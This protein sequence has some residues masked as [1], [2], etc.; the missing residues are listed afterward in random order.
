MDILLTELD[1]SVPKCVYIV[2]N[3]TYSNIITLLKLNEGTISIIPQKF[4][5]YIE[6]LI[7]LVKSQKNER[8]LKIKPLQP[9]F[10]RDGNIL[11]KGSGMSFLPDIPIDDIESLFG[12]FSFGEKRSS[13]FNK[14]VISYSA[15][16]AKKQLLD[17]RIN[18]RTYTQISG[19][20]YVII[21]NEDNF[22]NTSL[23]FCELPSATSISSFS[24]VNTKEILP[25]TEIKSEWQEFTDDDTGKIYYYN[26]STKVSVWKDSL[27]TNKKYYHKYLK[28]KQK[29]IKIHSRELEG[30]FIGDR[31][32]V[33]CPLDVRDVIKKIY[34]NNKEFTDKEFFLFLTG[35]R[36][37]Y[38]EGKSP[39]ISRT[40]YECVDNTFWV[41]GLGLEK[42]LIDSLHLEKAK[43][44]IEE[45]IRNESSIKLQE[46]HYDG[47]N[48]DV[49]VS[50]KNMHFFTFKSVLS[51]YK[52][53]YNG[54]IK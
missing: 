26:P 36:S 3:E 39:K 19:S 17:N 6:K 11:K 15:E 45:K 30:G 2:S 47:K 32:Y 35:P 41:N 1:K 52:L 28:Y 8:I 16:I 33:F 14:I 34:P 27:H 46:K 51:G 13:D 37:L 42:G 5:K 25:K 18:L 20:M 4:K 31:T 12:E 29:Y 40:W 7:L 24:T 44:Q 9:I 43:I 50:L 54:L 53:D 22:G 10:I 21:R 48:E 23:S 49:E 38:T